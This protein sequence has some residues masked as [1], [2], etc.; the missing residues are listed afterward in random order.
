M[1]LASAFLPSSRPVVLDTWPFVAGSPW[2]LQSLGLLALSW[3]HGLDWK[4]EQLRW[5]LNSS[6]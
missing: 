4:R 1:H 5:E 6:D 3:D 2:S